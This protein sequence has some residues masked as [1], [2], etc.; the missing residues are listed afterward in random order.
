MQVRL[1]EDLTDAIFNSIYLNQLDWMNCSTSC[2][3]LWIQ[4]IGSDR[5]SRDDIPYSN[6]QWGLLA[7][8][9]WGFKAGGHLGLFAGASLE[10]AT[11]ENSTQSANVNNYLGGITVEKP[12]GRFYFSG[13]L[14]SGYVGWD[15]KRRVMNNLAADGIETAKV[16]FSGAFLGLDL[17]GSWLGGYHGNRLRPYL[18]LTMRY[19]GFFLGNY[20]ETGSSANL[21]VHDRQVGVIKVR[22]EFALQ[23][24]RSHQFSLAPYLATAGRFQVAGNRV[25]SELLGKPLDFETGATES[26]AEGMLGLRGALTL[27]R[28]N[29][30]FNIEGLRDQTDSSRFLGSGGVSYT[31]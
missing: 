16:D 17:S 6:D 14:S 28:L 10:T 12:V 25:T 5:K 21:S 4:G 1:L 8:G 3:N 11:V 20:T 27:T 9:S 15:N 30:F 31:F 24:A 26:I 18:D 29:A 22:G 13:A 23:C 19:G 7:G 2:T